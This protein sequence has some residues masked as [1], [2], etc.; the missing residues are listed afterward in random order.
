M[1][2]DIATPKGQI[3]LKQEGE[4]LDILLGACPGIKVL[5]TP[6]DQPA[7][8][9]GVIARAGSII[10]VFESKCR[11][12]TRTQLRNFGDEWLVTFEKLQKGALLAKSLCVPFIGYLYLVPD[13]RVLSVR[14]ADDRGNFL[15]NIR[16]ERTETQA[17]T[18]GGQIIRTN[19]YIRMAGAREFV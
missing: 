18:N 9:D 4:M 1:S 17:T 15:P 10:A 8:V 7:D 14:I 13:R 5:Q 6:K 2:L 11:E 16:I 3:S 19:A 12:L